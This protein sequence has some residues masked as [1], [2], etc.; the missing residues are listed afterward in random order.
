[1]VVR[2]PT[3]GPQPVCLLPV[4]GPGRVLRAVV[5]LRNLIAVDADTIVE[6]MVRHS[7]S[8]HALTDREQAAREFLSH[9]LIAM[10]VTDQEDRLV[11]I[12]TMDDVLDI[13]DEED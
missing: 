13:M 3:D 8:T 11:G 6:D 2:A 12:L 7:I 4:V 9:R 10:P 5:S 1:A